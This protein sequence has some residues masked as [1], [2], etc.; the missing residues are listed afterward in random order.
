MHKL[1]FIFKQDNT[2]MLF[3]STFKNKDAAALAIHYQQV[4]A[5][6]SSLLQ[7]ILKRTVFSNLLC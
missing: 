7:T 5:L 6:A 4:N 1:H 2:I 3:V